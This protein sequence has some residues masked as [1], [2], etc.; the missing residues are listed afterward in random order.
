VQRAGGGLIAEFVFARAGIPPLVEPACSI[1][2]CKHQYGV[3]RLVWINRFLLLSPFLFS[4]LQSLAILH[5]FF[6]GDWLVLSIL[7]SFVLNPSCF[8]QLSWFRCEI[9]HF[10]LDPRSAFS[11]PLSFPSLQQ[12][13]VILKQRIFP[14]KFWTKPWWTTNK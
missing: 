11:L 8:V 12:Q 10:F 5:A 13:W 3:S 9:S 1:H 6:A 14:A 2:Y 4:F 7:L